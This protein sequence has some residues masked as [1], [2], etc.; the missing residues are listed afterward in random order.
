LAVKLALVNDPVPDAPVPVMVTFA[1]A[2]AVDVPGAYCTKI[3]QVFPAATAV[4]E[5]QVP[6]V[7]EK[8]PPAVPTLAIVGAALKVSCVPLAVTVIVPVLVVVL[9]G[10][11]VSTGAGA[12]TVAPITVKGIVLVAPMGVVRPRLWIPSVAVA[13]IARLAVTWVPVEL[14]ARLPA[15][16]VI[17]PPRPLIAVVPVRLAPVNVTGSVAVPRNPEFGLIEVT[18]AP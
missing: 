11:V 3:V 10:V 9:A 4:P 2:V 18:D 1:V 16:S 5:T 13:E 8:V 17:P 12:E 14:T 6:P 7:M 15:T